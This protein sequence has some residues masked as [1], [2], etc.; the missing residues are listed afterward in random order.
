[1]NILQKLHEIE[2]NKCIYD[3]HYCSGGV[4]FVF[5]YP[6]KDKTTTEKDW[7]WNV[8]DNGLALDKYYSTFEEAVEGEFK[9]LNPSNE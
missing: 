3:I 1:M 7:R 5:Y 9:K 4:G 2:Q 6:K 8:K